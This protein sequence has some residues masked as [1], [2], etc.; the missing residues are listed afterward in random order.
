MKPHNPDVGH[1]KHAGNPSP[2]P[3]P[4]Q[5]DLNNPVK[6]TTS[7]VGGISQARWRKHPEEHHGV[8]AIPGKATA[9]NLHTWG[10]RARWNSV[11][12]GKL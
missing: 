12:R 3:A 4:M 9:E 8:P 5:D 6:E 7:Y 10:L 2:R 11:R 1:I